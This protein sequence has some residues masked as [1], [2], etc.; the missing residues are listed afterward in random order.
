M[1]V[2]RRSDQFT[3]ARVRS[4]LLRVPGTDVAVLADALGAS[5]KHRGRCHQLAGLD[6]LREVHLEATA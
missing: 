4:P 3:S 2:R 1:K 5:G 6:R